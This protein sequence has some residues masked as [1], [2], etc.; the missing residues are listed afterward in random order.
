[1]ET[2]LTLEELE[3][4]TTEFLPDRLVMGTCGRSKCDDGFDLTICVKVDVCVNFGCS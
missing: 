2:A 4:E 3:L 1:M